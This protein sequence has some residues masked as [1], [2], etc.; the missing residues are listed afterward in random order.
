MPTATL[1]L[2]GVL[3][4]AGLSGASV[5]N[6]SVQDA[7]WATATSNNVATS[8]RASL[9]TPAGNP[10]AGANLQAIAVQTRKSATSGT[11]TP[12]ATISVGVGGTKVA[13]SSQF[14]VTAANA[15]SQTNSFLFDFSAIT[16]AAADGSNLEAW[17]D[18]TQSG[19]TTAARAAVDIGYLAWTVDYSDAGSG[20]KAARHSW[21]F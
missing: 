13:T 6:L 5:A 18:T 21:T 1:A 11:G 2:D 14:A 3:A 8:V 4:T 17:I 7:S 12:N 15:S 16:G 9:P 20:R 19:G 10:N